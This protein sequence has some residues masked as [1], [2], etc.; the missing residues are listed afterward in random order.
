MRCKTCL[1]RRSCKGRRPFLR[2]LRFWAAYAVC[3]VTAMVMAIFLSA[4][5]AP[6][7]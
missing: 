7:G 3:I 6:A 1:L 4:Y 2:G 5:L